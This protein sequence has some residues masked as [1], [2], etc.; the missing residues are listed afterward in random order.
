[1]TNVVIGYGHHFVKVVAIDS[2]GN[3]YIKDSNNAAQIRRLPNVPG[4]YELNRVN[5]TTR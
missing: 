4:D 3:I 5:V 1:M 2:D